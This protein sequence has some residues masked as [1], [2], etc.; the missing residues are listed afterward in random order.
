MSPSDK[1]KI[2]DF[3]S[4]S[5]GQM[6]FTNA[7]QECVKIRRELS[8]QR[9]SEPLSF[10]TRAYVAEAKKAIGVAFKD[11][12][13]DAAMI[14][15]GQPLRITGR[16]QSAQCAHIYGASMIC[17]VM[18]GWISQHGLQKLGFLI[19][20]LMGASA[21]YIAIFHIK[22]TPR[23]ELHKGQL[24]RAVK[25][26]GQAA[27][28]RIVIL[29]AVFYLLVNFNP[30]SWDVLYVHMTSELGFSEQFVGYTYTLNS[31]GAIVSCILYG[32]F[33]KRVPLRALLWG[34]VLFMVLSKLVY[35]GLGSQTSAV[36]IS[37][38]WG[39]IYM[40]TNL[41]QLEL[42]GRYCPPEAAGTVFALLMSL[43]NLS[44]GL[45]SIVGGWLYESMKP[46]W[47]T[48]TAYTVL[49]LIACGFTALC[50]ILVLFFPKSRSEADRAATPA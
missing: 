4:D 31:L 36:I 48:D 17:G 47:G 30:F 14:E 49:V 18:G 15:A 43:S 37:V 1:A 10:Y 12:T 5:L 34:S 21:L 38:S 40:V 29:V 41:T 32:I 35:V 8:G 3:W 7:S 23:P 24:K 16:I 27:R 33:A 26:L 28:T 6:M 46:S 44:V 50:G 22:E 13:T 2:A 20:A 25:V 42:A 19:G 39:L 11:V 9:G 45:S